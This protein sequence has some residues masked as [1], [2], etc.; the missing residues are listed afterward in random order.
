MHVVCMPST[1]IHPCHATCH[2]RVLGALRR[3]HSTAAGHQYNTP[4]STGWPEIF[5]RQAGAER[6]GPTYGTA[7]ESCP[8]LARRPVRACRC[9]A[10]LHAASGRATWPGLAWPLSFCPCAPNRAAR[11]RRGHAPIGRTRPRMAT[12]VSVQ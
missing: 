11:R 1:M 9:V 10:C 3:L 5:K 2:A 4:L 12:W 7:N 8:A 6:P